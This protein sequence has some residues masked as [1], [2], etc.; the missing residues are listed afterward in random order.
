MECFGIWILWTASALSHIQPSQSNRRESRLNASAGFWVGTSGF[1]AVSARRRNRPLSPGKSNA[2]AT[3]VPIRTVAV[4]Y[5]PIFLG[6]A[7]VLAA[8]DSCRRPARAALAS[9][10][11]IV[12]LV[13]SA[14]S[15]MN[16]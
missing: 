10:T 9:R 14:C 8:V 11:G 7:G 5:P 13:R 3:V 6:A 12:L 15:K 4:A 2:S 16:R 1:W